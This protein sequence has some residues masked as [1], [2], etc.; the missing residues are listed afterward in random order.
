MSKLKY[1]HLFEPIVIGN[2]LFRNRIFGSPTGYQNLPGNGH[3]VDGAAYYYGRKAMGGAAS[4]GTFEG[5]V[6]GEYG[7]G[8]DKHIKLDSPNVDMDIARIAD[9]IKKHG[10]VP[11]LELAHAGAFANRKLEMF[12]GEPTGDAI[13]PVAIEQKGRTVIPMDQALIDRTIQ[14]YAQA[15]AL[16]KRMGFGMVHIHAGHGWLLHQ[17][18]SP[19]VNT[20]TDEYGG[21]PENRC[22]IINQI[23]DA[24]HEACGKGFPV[25]VRI[26]GSEC[27]DGGFGFD[28]GLEN[29]IALDEHAD[30]IHVSAGNHEVDEVF[31][32][33]TPS[34]F[35][36]EGH[37][38]EM[39][40]EIKKHMKHAKVA[41]IGGYSD[42]AFMDEIIAT[43]KADVVEV[44]RE[45]FCEPD[46]PN[47]ARA[48]LDTEAKR[49][50]RC[51]NCFS[52]E[53][54][55]G[56]PYC[57][58]NPL[59]GREIHGT[60]EPPAVKVK[61]NVLVIGGG[62][63]GMEA[64]LT[65]ADR[66]HNVTIAEAKNELGGTIR[67]ERNV[68][69][70]KNLDYYLNQQQRKCF[71]HPNIK[72]MLNTK[73]TPEMAE[74]MDV[75]V[76]IAAL[77][78][79]QLIPPIPGIDGPN[80]MNAVDAYNSADELGQKIVIMGAGLAG[81]ELGLQLT[82]MGRDVTN[83]EML[84]HISDGG[85]FLH[86]SGV[87]VEI[88]KNG[89]KI[90]LQNKVKEV[91]ENGVLCETPDGEKFYEADNVIVAMGMRPLRE[92]AISFYDCAPEYYPI[93]DCFT[94]KNI[95]EATGTAF[96]TAVDLGRF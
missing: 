61:K 33:T 26:S 41:T 32:I 28:V 48:G 47:M 93:G 88:K 43:G 90:N 35:V 14:K 72:V 6:D 19:L 2:Q 70:K 36:D 23:C 55:N 73:M 39:A 62:V 10:A 22:R 3:L 81:V 82:K 24:I 63:A 49:C 76:I 34:M 95:C 89:L 1:P 79:K 31:G 18:L 27:Y 9:A 4:V 46:F 25:E 54:T 59:S 20:R 12:G 64:A 7:A 67:C 30:L 74:A 16:G 56:E 96:Q 50:M 92:E 91:K 58:I 77:G 83:V 66:G 44:A 17:F 40:A 38:L 29:A 87:R 13:G 21:S 78:S 5:I 15:A 84:D 53:L 57:A 11:V 42:P 52:Q 94:V 86:M 60:Y 75:D 80:V 85:N 65:A 51:M 71:E 8:S 45:L 69:F 37:N 68:Y